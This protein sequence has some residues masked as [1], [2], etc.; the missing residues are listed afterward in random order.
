MLHRVKH[1]V[2]AVVVTG[3]GLLVR[4]Y[5]VAIRPH[6]FG[7]CKFC[8]TCS[9]YALEALHRHGVARGIRLTLRRLARCHPFGLGGIDPVPPS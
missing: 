2:A 6:L 9:D 3:T 4:F 1:R 5:Q 8:P 7:S